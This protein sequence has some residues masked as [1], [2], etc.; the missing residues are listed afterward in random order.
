ME[1]FDEEVFG[2]VFSITKAK[3]E[4]EAIELAN[5]SPFGLGA[6]LFSKDI[7]K[8]KM[9]AK[10]KLD[11]GMCYINDFV[12]SDPELPFGGVKDSGHGRE[13]SINGFLEFVNVK[14][15]VVNRK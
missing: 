3:D 5:N 12:K 7:E 6:S 14:T 11:V 13:L 15:I 4:I 8:A 1:I 9:I 2:P 10:N